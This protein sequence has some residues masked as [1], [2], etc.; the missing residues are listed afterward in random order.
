M[1]SLRER[2]D[3]LL[4]DMLADPPRFS[5]HRDLPFAIVRYDPEDELAARR[6]ILLASTRLENRGRR[7]KLVSLGALM[8]RVVEATKG[9]E[10]IV[11]VERTLGFD[12]AERTVASLLSRQG[13]ISLPQLVAAEANG[14]DPNADVLFL[15]RGAALAPAAYPLSRLLHDLE[16][17][18]A[19]PV[20]LFYPGT[21]EGNSG[22]NFMNM[23]DRDPLGDYR[24]RVY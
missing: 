9:V 3:D 12:Y 11:E 4:E 23:S 22:L 6:E 17:K 18:L 7:A 5:P 1:S 21:L 24:V 10:K 19:V 13:S 20:I 8:W 2:I 14:L 15:V 16:G